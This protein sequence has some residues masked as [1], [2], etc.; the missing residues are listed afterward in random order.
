MTNTDPRTTWAPGWM[1]YGTV[2]VDCRKPFVDRFRTVRGG[3]TARGIVCKPCLD[4]PVTIR[5]TSPM[6]RTTRHQV[7]DLAYDHGLTLRPTIHGYQLDVPKPMLADVRT[8][9]DVLGLAW[10]ELEA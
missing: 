2:C 9:L 7:A 6:C 5:V 10:E 3:M 4:L 8:D 1:L